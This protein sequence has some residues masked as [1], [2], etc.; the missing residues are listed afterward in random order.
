MFQSTILRKWG[1]EMWW[2]GGLSVYYSVQ[3][4]QNHLKFKKKKSNIFE[5]IQSRFD[6]IRNSIITKGF[7]KNSK[8]VSLKNIFIS[9]INEFCTLLYKVVWIYNRLQFIFPLLLLWRSQWIVTKIK[10]PLA[11]INKNIFTKFH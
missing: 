2:T 3:T 11:W 10:R 5:N 1:F 6:K 9:K 4:I 8:R 7:K